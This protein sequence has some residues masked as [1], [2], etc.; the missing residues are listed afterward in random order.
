MES[1]RI[2]R[3]SIRYNDDVK[4]KMIKLYKYVKNKDQEF[5][6]A[7]DEINQSG[8]L[9]MALEL[10]YKNQHLLNVESNKNYS[11]CSRI[12]KDNEYSYEYFMREISTDFLQI[13]IKLTWKDGN[14]FI[15]RM[16]ETFSDSFSEKDT[17]ILGLHLSS[18][19][20]FHLNFEA[21]KMIKQVEISEG[22]E[23]EYELNSEVENVSYLKVYL[24]D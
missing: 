5:K 20:T 19:D 18:N 3:K 13:P 4:D 16:T 11:Y 8:I 14:M 15:S 1:K 21:I 17:D 2:Y 6:I 22:K 12:H 9:R 7:F 24:N 10:L 23:Y